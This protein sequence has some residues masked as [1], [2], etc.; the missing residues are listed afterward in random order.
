M[1]TMIDWH[2]WEARKAKKTAQK[3]KAKIA[4]RAKVIDSS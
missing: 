1:D 3:R 2:V 4:A